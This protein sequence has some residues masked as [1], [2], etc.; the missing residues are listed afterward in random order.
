[1]DIQQVVVVLLSCGGDARWWRD[2]Q[3]ASPTCLADH[4]AANVAGSADPTPPHN[5]NVV[6]DQIDATA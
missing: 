6:M 1:M 4:N 2:M 3:A 5:S